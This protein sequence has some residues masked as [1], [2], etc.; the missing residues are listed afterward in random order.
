MLLEPI[1]MSLY[2]GKKDMA[3]FY[4][5]KMDTT[6]K[7]SHNILEW[8]GKLRGIDEV[9]WKIKWVQKKSILW[10]NFDEKLRI[11]TLIKVSKNRADL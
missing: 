5:S 10:V 7:M 11:Y 4:L 3:L 1:L 6:I 8:K 2:E 9:N